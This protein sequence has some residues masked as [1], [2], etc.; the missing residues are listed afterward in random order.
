M[1]LRAKSR[2][3]RPIQSNS[4]RISSEKC[5]CPRPWNSTSVK[6]MPLVVRHRSNSSRIARDLVAVHL[7]FDDI[8]R[9]ELAFFPIVL[10]V[11]VGHGHDRDHAGPQVGVRQADVP[12]RVA[13]DGMP[14]EKHAIGIDGKAP[15]GVAQRVQHGQVLVQRVA[16]AALLFLAPGRRD[17][18]VAIASG[19]P[20]AAPV[21]IHG[22]GPPVDLLAGPS[23]RCRAA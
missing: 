1:S 11:L 6:F 19:L 14:G 9:D 12:G 8:Q 5:S 2:F 20:H 21:G 18:D 23:S 10:H 22:A 13:A 3:S 15:A 7:A 4:R 16:V 17:H